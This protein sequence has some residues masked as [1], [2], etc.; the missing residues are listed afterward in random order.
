[1][2]IHWTPAYIQKTS[3]QDELV[4]TAQSSSVSYAPL[5]KNSI[6]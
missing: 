4:V 3:D 6:Q 2:T 1:M 5:E